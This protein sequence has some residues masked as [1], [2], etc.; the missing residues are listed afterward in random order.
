[1][2]ERNLLSAIGKTV[3]QSSFYAAPKPK[4]ERIV[5]GAK[6]N[7]ERLEWG[8][9]LHNPYAEGALVMPRPKADSRIGKEIKKK[10]VENYLNSSET[11]TDTGADVNHQE[12]RPG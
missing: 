6:S 7:K 1:M 3:K 5:L 8:G 12:H 10:W 2:P 4:R 9:A 11:V